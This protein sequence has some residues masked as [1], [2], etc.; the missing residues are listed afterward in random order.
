MRLI[1]SLLIYT[2]WPWR[3]ILEEGHP[4]VTPEAPPRHP[5]AWSMGP[6]GSHMGPMGTR[7][8]CMGSHGGTYG[9]MR[10]PWERMGSPDSGLH[11]ICDGSD[12]LLSRSY[13]ICE[14]PGPRDTT[15]TE[16]LNKNHRLGTHPRIPRIPRKR[17]QEP[18]FRPTQ[19]RAGVSG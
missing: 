15:W 18:Q 5:P 1:R 11:D 16:K 9:H 8:G 6:I 13:G 19:T 4:R 14:A 2:P 10:L 17:C 12:M 7:G 3:G